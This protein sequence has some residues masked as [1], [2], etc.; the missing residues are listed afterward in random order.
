MAQRQRMGSAFGSSHG[1]VP[2]NGSSGMLI[3]MRSP[4]SLHASTTLSQTQQTSQY[5]FGNSYASI[6]AGDDT[7]AVDE[8]D[9]AAAVIDE[10]LMREEY[11][12]RRPS[13][14]SRDYSEP[15]SAIS[16]TLSHTS[17]T[18]TDEDILPSR[19]G[20][21]PPI[22]NNLTATMINSSGSTSNSSSQIQS[23]FPQMAFA[24]Q[25]RDRVGSIAEATRDAEIL[26]SMKT[27][28]LEGVSSPSMDNIYDDRRRIG[29]SAS[30]SPFPSFSSSTS[31]FTSPTQQHYGVSDGYP[32]PQRQPMWSAGPH[33][34]ERF[35]QSQ[36]M[37]MHSQTSSMSE[38]DMSYGGNQPAVQTDIL[39]EFRNPRQ[40]SRGGMS[41]SADSSFDYRNRPMSQAYYSSP[42]SPAGGGPKFGANSL[43][44]PQQIQQVPLPVQ[45]QQRG[46]QGI[47]PMPSGKKH[48]PRST[49]MPQ[50]SVST[51]QSSATGSNMYRGQTPTFEYTSS[52]SFA[53]NS[54]SGPTSGNSSQSASSSAPPPLNRRQTLPLT[55][56]S[57][58]A[59]DDFPH[60]VRSPLLEE[61]RSSKGKKY[62]LKDIYGHVVEFSGDQHGS[63]FIQQRLETANSDEKETIFGEIRSNSLQLMTDVFGNYV[64]QKFFEHGN[65]MQKT[66][67]AK[68]M[69]GHMLTL[70]LQMYGCRVV[71]KAIE[72]VLVDQQAKLVEE[73]EGHVLRCVKDQN[74]NHVIQKAIE[75][76][77]AE[78]IEFIIR[79]FNQQV[80]DLATH[81]YGCRVIQRMLEHCDDEAQN[82]ILQELHSYSSYLVQDQYGNYVIQHVIERGK[83]EDREKI[84]MVVRDNVLQFSKHKFASNVVE[85]CIVY[86]DSRQRQTVIDE[87]L[88]VKSDGS[89]PLTAMMK[90]Q[91]ANY[92]IQKLLDVT[93]GQQRDNL[94]LKI[95]PHL[96]A[97]KKYSYGKHLVSIEKLMYLSTDKPLP[98]SPLSSS[99]TEKQTQFAVSPHSSVSA[100]QQ[101]P[102]DGS[103]SDE[104]STPPPTFQE[105]R[106][107]ENS[108]SSASSAPPIS[109]LSDMI[110]DDRTVV[111]NVH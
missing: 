100:E 29:S 105:I 34:E 50:L 78:H 103:S 45:H 49:Q 98:L 79:S 6:V 88:R 94:V 111:T 18:R 85:K 93:S 35:Y 15:S 19:S 3:G 31:A 56:L 107:A 65:Q 53:R 24:A 40:Y 25:L 46:A 77:P 21:T 75:R 99:A 14:I 10:H 32:V 17:Q 63:R 23:P 101:T 58:A 11:A 2:N 67:L 74:G 76:V 9:I 84:I 20:S 44:Q 87:I 80:Y 89:L 37:L 68:Q 42:I 106:S 64:I 96:Q 30:S 43:Q 81:P 48:R 91:F 66:I 69:E 12:S 108:F 27:M 33:N 90:D 102:S 59:T 47:P 73:L 86:G 54:I 82:S 57:S 97:L 28:Q 70:S 61:F 104:T 60:G 95:T 71:Q 92:V 4:N 1:Q 8:E 26:A 51:K 83:P 110:K 38:Y 55:T 13:A 109:S 36:R 16:P 52:S 41:P 5:S 39:Q 22:Y 7:L 72:H 62:E